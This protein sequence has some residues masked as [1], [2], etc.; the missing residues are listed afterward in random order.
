MKKFYPEPVRAMKKMETIKDLLQ[1][2][3]FKLNEADSESDVNEA[4]MSLHL[5]N[6]L[7][8]LDYPLMHDIRGFMGK[9]VDPTKIPPYHPMV[10]N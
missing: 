9:P 7:L 5:A 6:T 10:L 2:V 3:E 1:F 4:I 8:H